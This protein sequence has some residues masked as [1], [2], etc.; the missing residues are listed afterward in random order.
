MRIE[1][2]LAQVGEAGLVDQRAGGLERRLASRGQ[3]L[4]DRREKRRG[5]GVAL[6]E[7]LLQGRL[8]LGVGQHEERRRVR[9]PPLPQPRSEER[10][11]GKECA[12]TCRSR[13]SPDE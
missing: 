4:V 10:R 8:V 2:A 13:W 11:G 1:G 6:A 7:G 9:L 5:A 3:L 12:S